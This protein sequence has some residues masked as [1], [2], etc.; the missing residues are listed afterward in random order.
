MIK[1]TLIGIDLGGTNIRAGLVKNGGIDKL[2]ST[3]VPGD[4]PVQD[5]LNE[6]FFLTDKLINEEVKGIGIG[7]P[8]L[9]DPGNGVVFD[10]INI[11]SWQEVP[12]Q[13]LM[14]KRYNLP[15]AV[16]NDANCFALG[17]Y[18]FGKGRNYKS[19]VGLTIGTGLGAGIILNGELY[20][21]MNGAAGEFGMIPYMDKY[22]EYYASGQ[23]FQ[24]CYGMDGGTVY[25]QALQGEEKAIQLYQEFGMHLGNAIK[26]IL[27]A[28]D[29]ECIILGGSVRHAYPY[30]SKTMWEQV[31][32]FA[33]ARTVKQLK[34]EISELENGAILGAAG[35]TFELL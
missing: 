1:E 35:L 23:F 31:K 18:C 25:Q 32:T 19:L 9:V 3:L 21:G 22:V 28:L 5:V 33:F 29:I 14:Q 12:L 20:S 4:G 24:N 13:Q 30:F 27:Y 26:T 2:V 6:L 8:G 34:I 17:E 11:A 7:V 10:V 15:V 16:N